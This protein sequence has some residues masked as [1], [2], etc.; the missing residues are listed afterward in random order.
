M[1]VLI[2]FLFLI[3]LLIYLTNT[4][5]NPELISTIIWIFGGVCISLLVAKLGILFLPFLLSVGF[6][7]IIIWGG[8][9]LSEFLKDQNI[10]EKDPNLE[11]YQKIKIQE[12]YQRSF[13]YRQKKYIEYIGFDKYPLVDLEPYIEL[14]EYFKQCDIEENGNYWKG[15]VNKTNGSRYQLRFRCNYELYKAYLKNWDQFNKFD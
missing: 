8:Q 5:G 7:I 3:W 14:K 12:R 2:L 9:K 6:L 4:N 15:V 11:P 10:N 13:T 1:A